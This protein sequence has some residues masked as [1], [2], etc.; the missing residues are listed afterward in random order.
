M[1]LSF[2]FPR[3]GAKGGLSKTSSGKINYRICVSAK[4]IRS[5]KNKR[6]LPPFLPRSTI[7][8]YTQHEEKTKAQRGM[9]LGILHIGLLANVNPL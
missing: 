1:R 4:K 9:E 5:P 8:Q 7:I 6:C 3:S 2:C